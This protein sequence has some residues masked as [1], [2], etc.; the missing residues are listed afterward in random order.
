MKQRNKLAFA[1]VLCLS[2]FTT[3]FNT[4]VQAATTITSNDTGNHGGY[5]YELWKDSGN[6]S[7]TLNDGGTF[8]CEWNNIGNALFRKGKKYNETQTHGQI[9]DISVKFGCDYQPN[10]NSY[11]CIYGWT[12]DPLVEYYIVESWGSWRP[13]GASSKGTIS[14]D[15]GTYD[16]YE[17]TRTNQPSIKGTATFQ[18]YWSVRT[19]KRT[20]G[21]ISVSDHF[22]AW[23]SRGMKMGKMFEVAFTVEGYQS[24]GKAN[25][26][27]MSID[28][29]GQGNDD[30]DDDDDDRD[31]GIRSAYDVIEA[32][33][34]NT[35]SSSTIETIGT[36]NAGEGIG[37]IESGN[38]LTYKDIDFG[39]GGGTLFSAVV[40]SEQN[41]NI[42]VR[43]GNESGALLGTLSDASTGGWD[44]YENK[45]ATVSNVTGKQD[46]I[47]VFSGPVNIDSFKFSQSTYE[48]K[49]GD[50]NGDR[51]VDS[52]DFSLLKSYILNNETSLDKEAADINSDGR[53]DSLDFSKLKGIILNNDQPTPTP[54]TPPSYDKVVALTFDDGPD[55]TLTPLVLNKLEKYDIPATFMVIGQK[56]NDSTSSIVDRI[57]NSGSEIGNHSWSYSSMNNMSDAEIRQSVNDTSTAIKRYSGTTP[58]F[59]RAPNLA[60]SNTMFNVIDLT[61]VGGVTCNDWDQSSTAQQRADAIINGARDGAILLM[62]DVQPSPHPTPEALDIIIPTL[63]EQGYQFVT[64]S[65]L[66]EIKGVTLNPYDNNA[67]TYVQ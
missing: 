12:V 11:L 19:S 10:G 38:T 45:S 37:Y 61:F 1:M 5:D 30:D 55:T 39:S 66:F 54:T 50:V 4:N 24:S 56:L 2:I 15:G 35:K 57:I 7:M 52:L 23:E 58:I 41:T 31:Y 8:S 59:F 6:T 64:L 48:N 20:S 29:N 16:I 13:P 36:G 53:V 25:V 28:I 63:L 67:Y 33:E 43:L 44:T 34:Y 49:I 22:K 9:G 42:Q 21:T 18:Q 17:T 3:L 47:L 65:E 14:V 40:A 62:H 46:I 51:V 60:T 27:T 26:H 32:E